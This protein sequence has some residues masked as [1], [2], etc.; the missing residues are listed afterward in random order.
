ME[1][2]EENSNVKLAIDIGLSD[3]NAEKGLLRNINNSNEIHKHY[4]DSGKIGAQ[5]LLTNTREALRTKSQSD[6]IDER[7]SEINKEAL[8]IAQHKADDQNFIIGNIGSLDLALSPFGD[9]SFE[10]AI[11]KYKEQ[12]K[13]LSSES[14]GILL[15]GFKD[16]QNLRAAIIASRDIS[17]DL[18]LMV[19]ANFTENT[20]EYGTDVET[21][22]TIINS[23]DVNAIGLNKIELVRN[24]EKF[25]NLPLIA[26]VESEID[27]DQAIKRIRNRRLGMIVLS[28]NIDLKK[29]AEVGKFTSKKQ[30]KYG[31]NTFPFK[32]T[33][34]SKTVQSGPGL[35]FL[36][37]GERIN[38]TGREKLARDL[39]EGNIEQ[40][41]KD[42]ETQRDAGADALDV[43]VGTPMIDE[44]E[45]MV[46][47]IKALQRKF[48][49]PLIIDSSTPEVIEAGLQ[50]YAGKVLVNSVDGDVK[51]QE[52]ILPLVKKYG[53]AIIGL[54]I[55]GG[56]PGDADERLEIAQNI[57]TK[58]KSYGIPEQNIIIDTVAMSAATSPQAGMQAF[59]TIRKIKG[60]LELPTVMGISNS[61]FGLPNRNWVHNTF[62]VQA[63]AY[64]LDAG[65][66]NVEDRELKKLIHTASIFVGRD[67]HC[68]DYIKYVRGL[69]TS[70]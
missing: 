32:I 6:K 8:K 11:E 61:S 23:F 50:N 33:S 36:K 41:I 37:I 46:R 25:T 70:I 52:K 49:V 67:Q 28:Q 5:L 13:L 54:T 4:D 31:D 3:N 7:F 17:S 9:F 21:F 60:K 56:Q 30:I 20:M 62:L 19:V 10:T 26:Y 43:N 47:T 38:P 24:L 16:I 45:V 63:M 65:I 68:M 66:V 57:V 55:K 35:P 29:A 39:K 27:I 15:N 69:D 12:I 51:K 18:P 59:D 2:L 14:D 44:K 64:G 53:A 58:C 34:Y 48:D 1:L 42:A 22:A 40:I